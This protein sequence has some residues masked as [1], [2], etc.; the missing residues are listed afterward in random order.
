MDP[1]VWYV[2]QQSC[3]DRL[4]VGKT[5]TNRRIA[6]LQ[7]KGWYGNGG[8]LEQSKDK[9]RKKARRLTLSQIMKG[10]RP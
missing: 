1:S 3:Y 4:L 7:K 5:L 8:L 10:F 9:A 2:T 6:R